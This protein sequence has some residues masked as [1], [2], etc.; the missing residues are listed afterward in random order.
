MD[1][2]KKFF[3]TRYNF[4]L[5]QMVFQA[6]PGPKG[7]QISLLETF[8]SAMELFCIFGSHQQHH[9]GVLGREAAEA[10]EDK[11]DS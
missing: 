5:Q 4:F 11:K 10:G 3:F 8:F 2:K 6:S 7:S 1:V 9:L